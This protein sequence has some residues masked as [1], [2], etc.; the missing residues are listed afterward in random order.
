MG[1]VESGLKWLFCDVFFERNMW[2]QDGIV[3]VCFEITLMHFIAV[4]VSGVDLV[5]LT[6]ILIGYLF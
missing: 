1:R 4:V 3:Y 2:N 5:V 6:D